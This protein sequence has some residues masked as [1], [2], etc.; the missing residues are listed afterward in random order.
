MGNLAPIVTASS[1][2]LMMYAEGLLKGITPDIFARM[3]TGPDGI[4]TTNHPAFIFGHLSIYPVMIM[5][6]CGVEDFAITNPDGFD[7]LF[8]H[9]TICKDDPE[10]TIYPAMEAVTTH[11]YAAHKAMFARIAELSD[12]QLSEPH[13]MEDE[14]FA[15]WPSRGAAASFMA[16]SHTFLHIGQLS[17]WRRCMGLG[18]AF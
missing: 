16:G 3:P 14:F 9:E 18:S 11:F 15:K 5:K 2:P 1:M 17:T 12:E 4:I 8:T 10:G 6:I 7:E 13:G